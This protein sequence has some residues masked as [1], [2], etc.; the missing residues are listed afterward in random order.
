MSILPFRNEPLTDFSDPKNVAAFEAALAKV[1]GEF[2]RH[3]D[4]LIGGE[5]V[6]TER[7]IESRDPADPDVVVGTVGRATKDLAQRAVDEAHRVF[8]EYWQWTEPKFR[9][10]I[11]LKAAKLLRERK[12]EFSAT[13][14]YEESKN[15]V[16]A[17]A[18]TAETID[19]LEFYARE[20][21]RLGGAQ[22]V[23]PYPG[24]ENNLYYIPLGVAVVIPPWNFPCAIMGGMTSA[25]LVTGNTVV[26]KP[27][28][29]APV[30]AAKF[31]E[32]MQDAGLPKGVLNFCPGGGGEV[33][34]TLVGHPKTRLIAF[35]GSKEVGLHIHELAAKHQPGQVWIK[36][37]ILEMG[38]KDALVVDETADLDY[39]AEQAV[40]G[41]FG[42]QGQKCSAMSRLIVTAPVYDEM[43][44]KVTERA[45][46]LVVG[47]PEKNTNLG[48]VIDAAAHGKILEYIRFGEE[49]G[50]KIECGGK[51]I[52]GGWF[53][54]P[55]VFSGVKPDH[56]IARE[57]IFGPVLAVI[58]ADDFD[59]AVEIFNGTEYGLTGG[60][61]SND[62]ER[63]ERARR[64]FFVGNLYLNRKITGALV[65]VQPF[66]GFNMSGTDSKAGGRDYLQLFMQAKS[67]AERL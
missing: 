16:E 35:T 42:F 46:K 7:V 52:E 4:L 23:V 36:R 17:D 57:E 45:K 14:V 13:M 29:T 30:V 38:G 37:T 40:I 20:M 8:T 21:M 33:G 60:L 54:E 67:V 27:A 19:F 25:A 22:P 58:K 53:V 59:H 2:G 41:A 3:W 64:E 11:L 12:H 61:I 26:L 31:V 34:D 39:A 9:A 55:T 51:A 5:T 66:G 15:W 28:S 49:D 18:D 48:A 56:R 63:L 24:E 65:G 47:H 50:G 62:R 10:R 32:L 1:K 44:R 6:V 43:V